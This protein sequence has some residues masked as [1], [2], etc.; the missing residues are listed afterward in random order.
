MI[1]FDS[2]SISGLS[3]TE[4]GRWIAQ[5]WVRAHGQEGAWSFEAVDVARI[6]LIHTLRTDMDIDDQ[7]MPVVLSLLD[8]LYEF[9]RNAMRLN[10]ALA[11]L[12]TSVRTVILEKLSG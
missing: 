6:Q 3:E 10:T 11:D 7:A 12:P 4:L 9:R 2:L 1:S 8:Q 5:S